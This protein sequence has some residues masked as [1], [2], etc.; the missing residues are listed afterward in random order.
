MEVTITLQAHFVDIN[1]DKTPMVLKDA[2]NMIL[3]I[4]GVDY[5]AKVRA[6]LGE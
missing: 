3:M 4:G 5:M 1:I 6:N 2:E